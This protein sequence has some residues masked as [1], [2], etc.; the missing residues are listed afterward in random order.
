[1]YIYRERERE[2]EG[3]FLVLKKNVMDDSN[4]LPLT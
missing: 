3:D 4:I 2:R 1:M